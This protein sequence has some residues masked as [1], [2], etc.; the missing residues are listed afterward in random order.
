MPSPRRGADPRRRPRPGEKLEAERPSPLPNNAADSFTA[1]QRRPTTRPKVPGGGGWMEGTAAPILSQ[2]T[3]R[4]YNDMNHGEKIGSRL[5]GVGSP[6]MPA[7]GPASPVNPPQREPDGSRRLGA[8]PP[9]AEL[10][11]R[12]GADHTGPRRSEYRD[13]R[14]A[15]GWAPHVSQPR[16]RVLEAGPRSVHQEVGRNEGRG[17]NRIGFAFLFFFLSLIFLS[18]FLKSI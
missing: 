3:A 1:A 6:F 15:D 9:C 12:G 10:R 2:L 14:E 16:A 4:C 8:R 11:W 5:A 17:P 18:L 13:A 7:K